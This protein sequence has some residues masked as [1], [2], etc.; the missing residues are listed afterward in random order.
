MQ[1]PGEVGHDHDRALEDADEQEVLARVV[2]IDLGG[3]LAQ[4]L[5]DLLLGEEDVLE[6]GRDV[7]RLHAGLPSRGW[8]DAG[9]ACHTC[10]RL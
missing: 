8:S 2:A 4:P 1:G 3:Q 6:L 5:V 7:V 10:V 9:T